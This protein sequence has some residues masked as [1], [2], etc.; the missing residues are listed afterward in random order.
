MRQKR[1]VNAPTI[2]VT[3]ASPRVQVLLG[4]RFGRFGNGLWDYDEE[5]TPAVDEAGLPQ[6]PHEARLQG[7]YSFPAIP[8]HLQL[9][10]AKILLPPGRTRHRGRPKKLPAGNLNGQYQ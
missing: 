1:V 6:E 8:H 5:P 10:T 2:P 3:E 9:T 7:L 4:E